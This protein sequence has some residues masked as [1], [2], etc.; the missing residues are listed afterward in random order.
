MRR[1]LLRALSALAGLELG[2]LVTLARARLA[3]W[4]A[5]APRSALRIKRQE[6]YGAQPS[7]RGIGLPSVQVL[8]HFRAYMAAHDQPW[9]KVCRGSD[10][11][12]SGGD[13]LTC[14]DCY[15]IAWWDKRSSAEILEVMRRGDA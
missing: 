6:T 8:D 5:P 2:D 1:A 14:R 7:P 15:T 9:V 4:I 12:C 3:R 11:G 13:L 10:K